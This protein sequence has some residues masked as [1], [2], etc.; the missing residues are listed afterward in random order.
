M[1]YTHTYTHTYIYVQLPEEDVR[2]RLAIPLVDYSC[3]RTSALH[4]HRRRGARTACYR[5]IACLRACAALEAALLE[6]CTTNNSSTKSR[7]DDAN[8]DTEQE[9]EGHDFYNQMDD[10]ERDKE[11]SSDSACLLFPTADLAWAYRAVEL[12]AGELRSGL[13][14]RLAELIFTSVVVGAYWAKSVI[15]CET[16]VLFYH[17][18]CSHYRAML[19]PY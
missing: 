8:Q 6:Q 14:K 16:L 10:Q 2:A 3:P 5:A 18:S 7:S 13:D 1:F 19:L 12:P 9:E 11:H 15:H 4:P 17:P